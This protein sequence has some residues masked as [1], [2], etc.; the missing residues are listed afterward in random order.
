MKYQLVAIDVDGTLLDE[1]HRLSEKNKAAL[2]MV[3]E[4]G[5]KVVLC[6]GRG[7]WAL[8]DLIQT[9]G[10]KNA[11]ITQNGSQITDE[12]GEKILH[13]EMISVENC[14]KILSH[15]VKNGYHPLIYQKDNVYGSLQDQYLEI[16]ERCMNQ[17]VVYTDDVERTYAQV[18]L[19]KILVLDEPERIRKIQ[20]WM[21][22]QFRG[23]VLAELA[24]DFSLE[25]GGSDKG[26]A[27]EWLAGYYQ[28]PREKILAIG[29]GENDKGMLQYAGFG[30]AMK[31]A[32]E[33]VKK[34]ADA[35]TLSNNES[36]VADAIR[37]YM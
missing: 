2:Q 13:E 8:Q 5:G 24:Y 29:D 33:G 9:L 26:K 37:K 32:M 14:K 31:G 7:Y 22:E 35:V 17:K 6:S 3:L 16:F 1:E 21:L 28:I 36:G 10:I 23:Q 15:C 11:V 19:G 30:V 27:L 18:P 4:K 34:A 25:I 20:N 12:T